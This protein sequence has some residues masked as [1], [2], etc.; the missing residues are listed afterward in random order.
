MGDEPVATALLIFTTLY[1]APDLGWPVSLVVSS[2]MIILVTYSPVLRLGERFWS[3][4]R[5]FPVLS[6]GGDVAF[7]QY[8]SVREEGMTA[9][10]A[11]AGPILYVPALLALKYSVTGFSMGQA[12]QALFV[13][14]LL[15]PMMIVETSALSRGAAINLIRVSLISS[16]ASLASLRALNY[17]L[18]DAVSTVLFSTYFS[19]LIGMDIRNIPYFASQGAT[20]VVIGGSGIRDALIIVPVVAAS[21]TW[22]LTHIIPA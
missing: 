4:S 5:R 11:L 3:L 9:L 13:T 16:T 17:S 6:N 21:L 19:V 1:L 14:A 18:S 7:I 20:D 2:A 12:V 15:L 10:W 22:L 8:V